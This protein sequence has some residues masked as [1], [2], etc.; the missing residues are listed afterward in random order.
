MR[1]R[2]MSVP[3]QVTI[4]I[5]TV[6]LA[7]YLATALFFAKATSPFNSTRAQ[8]IKIAK[9]QA[10]LKTAEAF[11]IATTDSTSYAVIGQDNS[12]KEI[13]V[14][15]PKNNKNLT[16]V[17]MADG[18]SPEKLTEKNTSS[19]VLALYKNKPAWEVNDS[20]GFKVYD[21]TSG[22]KLLG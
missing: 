13:G 21:F 3:A 16:V 5:L 20:N 17:N 7:I 1:K 12:G 4:G 11:G 14:I 9:A 2:R 22:K 10:G 18:I 19:V 6:V 8:V 15:I